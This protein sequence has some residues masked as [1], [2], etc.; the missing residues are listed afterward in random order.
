M[1][2]LPRPLG[3]EGGVATKLVELIVVVALT[4]LGGIVGFT[5]R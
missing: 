2:S 3:W 5:H 4:V 1:A